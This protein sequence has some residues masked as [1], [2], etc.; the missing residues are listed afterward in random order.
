MQKKKTKNSLFKTVLAFFFIHF[1]S[2]NIRYTTASP[3][4]HRGIVSISKKNCKVAFLY[5]KTL[6]PLS[7]YIIPKNPQ[8]RISHL[9][10]PIDVCLQPFY[11]FYFSLLSN[12]S[13][14]PQGATPFDSLRHWATCVEG[15]LVQRKVGAHIVE[16]SCRSCEGKKVAICNLFT[17]RLPSLDSSH[18]F[19]FT[20]FLKREQNRMEHALQ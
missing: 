2:N 13:V 8:I 18:G 4:S 5:R 14:E 1:P 10:E 9:T 19:S 20:G 6:S 16:A 3:H 7:L 11:F 17:Y 15:I 12:T